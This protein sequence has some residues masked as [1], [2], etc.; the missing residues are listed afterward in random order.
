[1]TANILCSEIERI[2]N[3]EPGYEQMAQNAK[4]FSH[5]GAAEKIA[6]E[7]VNIALGHEK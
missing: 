2:M 7:L 6:R 3:D 5:P 4:M 1:M